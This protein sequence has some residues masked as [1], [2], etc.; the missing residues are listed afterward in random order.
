MTTL[1]EVEDLT[2]QLPGP[3][4]YT[5][6]VDGI[7]FSLEAGSVLGMA[8][9]SGSGKSMTGLALLQLLPPRARVTGRIVYE[10]RELV[11]IH[12]RSMQ[13][14]RGTELAMVFQDPMSSLHP[15]LSIGKTLTGP[16]RRHFNLSPKEAWAR[17]AEALETVRIPD[18]ESAMRA[19]PHQFSGGM[20]QRIAIALALSC[21]PKLLIA[22][23]PTTALD[24]TVQAG[25]MSLL[26]SIQRET[27]MGVILITHDLGVMSSLADHL[28]VMYAGRVA[29]SGSTSEV[30]QAPLHPYTVG[31]LGSLPQPDGE[32]QV[33]LVPI[34]GSPPTADTI[35]SGCALHPR[36]PRA[37]ASCS[38]DKPSLIDLGSRR[39]ACPVV[40][41]D[42]V[43]GLVR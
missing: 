5:T 3:D 29:E 2:V 43:G 23:E 35:P 37:E 12:R 27:G 41:R 11:G 39:V 40:V 9:E 16:L 31:L 19:Y 22:D 14:L 24:V 33:P 1:L 8:G 7:S 30:L 13:E 28:V 20:R 4:G 21:R 18:P 32:R 38:V 26:S 15:M 42:G 36:C 25:V 10:G 6:V 34:P 17:A